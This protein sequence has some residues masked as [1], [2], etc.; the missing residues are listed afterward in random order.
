MLQLLKR[1]CWT[2]LLM[3]I[4]QSALAFSY[5]GPF[6]ESWQAP[7]IGY[8]LGGDIGGPKNVGEEYRRN[9]PVIYYAYD[10]SFDD[11]FGSQGRIAV[12]QA[13]AVF[14]NLTNFSSYS[15]NLSEFPLEV[16][17]FNF[18]A[19][20]LSLMDLKSAAMNLM[21]EE[22]GLT[23]PD[24]YVWTLRSRDTQP[25]LACPFM[26][27][28]VI[29]RNYDPYT[30]VYTPYIN[31]TLY[32]YAIQEFCTGPNPLAFTFN[33]AVD[34]LQNVQTAV[35]SEG[36]F[37]Y[38]GF[39][40]GLTRDDVGGLRA[41]MKTNNMNVEGV[42]PDSLQ[43]I[44]NF[45]SQLLVTSNL[46][47]LI[48]QS[49]T[50]DPATLQGLYPGLIV[51]GTTNFYANVVTTNFTAFFA[52]APYAPAGTV[53]L[54][55]ATNLTTNVAVR[56]IQTFANVVTNSYFKRGF[57]TFQQ[58]NV[59]SNPFG[60]VGSVTTNVT[61]ATMLTNF[62]NGDFYIVPTNLCGYDIIATQ[63]VSVLRVTNTFTLATNLPGVTNVNNQFFSRDTISYFTNH[64]FIVYPIVCG[65]N[66]VA[67]RQGIDKIRFIKTEVDPVTGRYVT[68]ITNYY[69]LRAL[70]PT[71]SQLVIQTFRRILFQPDLLFIAENR[72][73]TPDA[74]GLEFGY[75]TVPNYVSDIPTNNG[76]NVF[77]PGTLQSPLG[78][79]ITME[80]NKVGPLLVNI[81][82]P[83]FF[84]SGLSQAD[85]IT[86][87]V[88]GSF[89]G[90]TNA[91]IIYPDGA[92][93]ADLENQVLFSVQTS[94][95]PDG[96]VG[97]AYSAQ[98]QAVGGSLPFSWAL[99]PSSAALPDG[100]FLTSDGTITGTPTTEGTYDFTVQVTESGGQ[101]SSR[102]LSI[103]ISP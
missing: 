41:L 66:T 18:R 94:A 51:S 103:T 33:F 26:I 81:Y 30:E 16:Q 9:L 80:F 63:L 22:L 52:G 56:F 97:V 15:T 7:V 78:A 35:A 62:P 76:A 60:P 36:F 68:P 93:I 96:Q 28:N 6:N 57:L 13:V 58:T 53:K 39:L 79:P 14:N 88:W 84:L 4:G 54:V 19:Q 23:D 8:N 70:N 74:E 69:A 95:L 25:N 34:P 64:S 89:D 12:D 90:T 55:L 50:N 47:T 101:T 29:M 42:S 5:L 49:L 3:A 86:N 21:I 37:Q 67:K 72:I 27:Y 32:S 92:S 100:L 44:T 87:F 45:T 61:S 46:A 10:Q 91:P 99:D 2:M 31:G 83:S 65:T 43:I 24:R 77:G 85:G 40:T 102:D 71:N 11:Y 75:R 17:R 1:V 59:S 48:A 98:L 20:A 82:T 38:G 73:V